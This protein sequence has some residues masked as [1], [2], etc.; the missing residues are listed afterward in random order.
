MWLYVEALSSVPSN[1]HTYT[2]MQ[3]QRSI[4]T[5]ESF[6]FTFLA[7]GGALSRGDFRQRV[8]SLIQLSW[9]HSTQHRWL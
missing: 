3:A 1:T 5:E 7:K 4:L 9:V 2:G 6:S 8:P